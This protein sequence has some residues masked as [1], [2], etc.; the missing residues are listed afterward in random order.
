MAEP[1]TLP[2]FDP[3]ATPQS[4]NERMV[5]GEYAILYANLQPPLLDQPPGSLPPT[6]PVCVVFDNLP[7]AEAYAERQAAQFPRLRCN[8]YDHTGMS[9]HPIR[10][11]CG[12]HG[13]DT[14]EISAGF[15]RWGGSVLLLLSIV[16]GIAEWRSGSTLTWAG[17]IASR[18]APAGLILL[19]TE[20]AIVVEARLKK[21]RA[22][23]GKA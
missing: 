22:L 8:I 18:L 5:P 17:T 11:I 1:R 12:I 20:L 9:R 19:V 10:Q 3:N 16:L 14:N 4:W 7:A 21:R 6:G 15:R 13:R 2:L 23:Q